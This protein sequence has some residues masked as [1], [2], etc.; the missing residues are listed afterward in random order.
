VESLPSTKV[1]HHK[2]VFFQQYA[3]IWMPNHLSHTLMELLII[4]APKLVLNKETSNQAKK[5]LIF[6]CPI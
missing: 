1:S 2:L 4:Q 6:K 3:A 5:N